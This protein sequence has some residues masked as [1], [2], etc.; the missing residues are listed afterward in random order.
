ML[1]ISLKFLSVFSCTRHAK[2]VYLKK[3]LIIFKNYLNIPYI[4]YLLYLKIKFK[5]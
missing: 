5:M 2:K 4:I 3:T 1:V